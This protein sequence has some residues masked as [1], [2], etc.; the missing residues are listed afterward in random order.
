MWLQHQPRVKHLVMLAC[1]TDCTDS[2]THSAKLYAM[3]PKL[4]PCQLSFPESHGH[5]P[6]CYTRTTM[7]Y[8]K[9]RQT[10]QAQE[11]LLLGLRDHLNSHPALG[12]SCQ[13]LQ[14]RLQEETCLAS[15]L[16]LTPQVLDILKAIP[17]TTWII[18]LHVAQD[19]SALYCA[20]VKGQQP[21]RTVSAGKSKPAKQGRL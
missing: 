8:I 17:P 20:A 7:H 19:G 2:Q 5:Q 16:A 18:S 15:R 4:H 13:R 6:G 14:H 10:V 3:D 21:S 11:Q 9:H 1:C 12:A